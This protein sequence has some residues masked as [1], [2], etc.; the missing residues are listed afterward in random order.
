MSMDPEGSPADKMIMSSDDK[1]NGL[2]KSSSEMGNESAM[3]E[4]MSM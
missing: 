1:N 4:G 3:P 2:N